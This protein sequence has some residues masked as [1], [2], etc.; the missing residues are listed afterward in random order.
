M[1]P[2]KTMDGEWVVVPADGYAK[3]LGQQ[4]N[5]ANVF[6]T[7]GLAGGLIGVLVGVAVCQW[8]FGRASR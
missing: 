7:G 2:Y 5:A 6:L 4:T 3:L 1:K 8:L